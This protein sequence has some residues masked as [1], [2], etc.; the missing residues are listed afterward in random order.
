MRKLSI[1]VVLLLAALGPSACGTTSQRGV[2][3]INPELMNLSKEEVWERA[4]ALY[5][6][7]RWAAARSH[8]SFIYENYPNDPLGR[9]SL[10]RVA[11]TYFHQGGPANLVEAQYKYRDF[12]NRYPGSEQADY[13]MLQIANVSFQQM[14]PAHN[15]QTKTR[16]ALVKYQEMLTAFPNSPLRP[17]AEQKVREAK[18]RLALHEHQVAKFYMMRGAWD[19]A[20]TRLNTIVDQYPDYTARAET[21]YDLG[22]ALDS[23]GREGEARL[24]FERVIAE[25]PDSDFAARAREQLG[26]LQS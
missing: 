8:Y 26:A 6:S 11:D 22:R 5:E 14:E 1:A 9:R 7:E 13:A 4:E 20:V 10:L 15:D 24:Y 3:P 17:Q 16:E 18:D 19:A 23:L 21:F 25:F 12:I 2:A